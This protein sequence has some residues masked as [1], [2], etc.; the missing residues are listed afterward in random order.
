MRPSNKL[1]F[2]KLGPFKILKILGPVMYKLDFP[3][4]IKIT[5]IR[6]VLI[7]KL[8]DLEAPLIKDISDIDSESEKKV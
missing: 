7:L 1:D 4:S 5:R 3:N 2:I 8:I 6:Y